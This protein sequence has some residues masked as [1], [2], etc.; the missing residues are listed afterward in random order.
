LQINIA[1]ASAVQA[2]KMNHK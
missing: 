1:S 2:L